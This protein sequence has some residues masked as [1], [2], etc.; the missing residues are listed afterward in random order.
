MKWT[1]AVINETLRLGGP[2]AS[3]LPRVVVEKITAGGL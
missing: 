2:A 1:E 3:L